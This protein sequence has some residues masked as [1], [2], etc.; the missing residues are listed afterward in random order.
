MNR[1]HLTLGAIALT[2]GLTYGVWYS[3]SVFLVAL[4]KDFGWSRS[5]LAGAFSVF[6]L[7][8][9][10]ANPVIGMLC[11]RVGPRRLVIFGGVALGLALYGNS[12]IDSPERLYLG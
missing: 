5:V 3:Y 11:D 4:L 9:G 1:R 7:V 2:L 6:T 10:A 8:H 12:F